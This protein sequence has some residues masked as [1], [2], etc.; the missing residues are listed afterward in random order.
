[1]MLS[2]VISTGAVRDGFASALAGAGVCA[3]GVENER[4]AKK[5]A[6]RPIPDRGI[7]V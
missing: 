6:A 1:M 7:V 4:A 3:D 2:T 5:A